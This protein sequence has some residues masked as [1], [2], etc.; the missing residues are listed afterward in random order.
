[1]SLINNL[2]KELWQRWHAALGQQGKPDVGP[3][4]VD[5]TKLA[6]LLDY[7]GARFSFF[8]LTIIILGELNFRLIQ[9]IVFAFLGTLVL[10]FYL[11][12]LRRLRLTRMVRARLQQLPVQD[13]S[14]AIASLTIR[15]TQPSRRVEELI[16][17]LLTV[18][19]MRGLITCGVF[20]MGFGVFFD[21][22]WRAYFV[23]FGLLDVLLAIWVYLRL[24][25]R[26]INPLV[27]CAPGEASS[28]ENP[29]EKM[30]PPVK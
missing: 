4:P 24:S 11:K 14:N 3:L 5:Q 25:Q 15:E 20:L 10:H 7:Y 16:N 21:Q 26:R 23:G 29:C 28:K 18:R 9:A 30:V 6:R 27:D 12:R 1:M 8:M 22:W 19:G 17:H 2:I 13:P